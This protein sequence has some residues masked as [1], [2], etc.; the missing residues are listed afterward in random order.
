VA[1][2]W[3]VLYQLSHQHPLESIALTVLEDKPGIFVFS[4]SLNPFIPTNL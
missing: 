4:P 1:K 2:V 3:V